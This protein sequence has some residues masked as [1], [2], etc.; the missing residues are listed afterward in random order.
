VPR[1]LWALLGLAALGF[2]ATVL[3]SRRIEPLEDWDDLL[4]DDEDGRRRSPFPSTPVWV[5]GPAGALHVD[6]GGSGGLPVLFVHGLGGA[7]GHWQAQL[8]HLRAERRALAVDLRGHGRSEA[9]ADGVYGIEAYADDVAATIGELGLESLVLVGHSLGGAVAAEVAARLPER[10]AGLVLVDPNGDQTL[11]PRRELEPFLAAL[12]GDPHGEMRSYFKQLLIAAAPEVA[13]RV[14]ADLAEVPAE[15]FGASIE[16][17]FAFSPVAA[18]KRYAGPRLS[19]ISDRNTLPVSLHNLLPN[20]PVRLVSGT[21]HW[22]MMDRPDDLD[23][24]LAEF[25]ATLPAD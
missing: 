5:D 25:L 20:L 2:V 18:L 17:S 11:L 1:P 6:D 4:D 3:S 9:P 16:S 24:L 10:V 14:L 12:A 23:R 15:A 8:D 19:V 21:S 22:L 13:D 7:T